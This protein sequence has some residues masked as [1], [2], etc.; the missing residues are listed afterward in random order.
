MDDLIETYSVN[1]IYELSNPKSFFSG[2]IY[3]VNDEL[4]S[5]FIS[6]AKR[7]MPNL[8]KGTVQKFRK[9]K[10]I[11]LGDDINQGDAINLLY[12]LRISDDAREKIYGDITLF[13]NPAEYSAFTRYIF[14]ENNYLSAE[15]SKNIKGFVGSPIIANIRRID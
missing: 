15:E 9:T 2:E 14:G 7:L 13:H 12:V 4:V 5:A 8:L 11:I 10:S 6:P 1:G 3:I